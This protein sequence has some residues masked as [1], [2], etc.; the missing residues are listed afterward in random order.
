MVAVL[1]ASPE[2]TSTVFEL[3]GP[4]DPELSP[5]PLTLTVL[6][7]SLLSCWVTVNVHEPVVVIPA[8]FE[9][10]QV[11]LSAHPVPAPVVHKAP[12]AQLA[13]VPEAV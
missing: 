6:V 4:K 13:V 9:D 10:E 11:V 8:M 1:G 5:T 2:M 12:F 3:F 7:M